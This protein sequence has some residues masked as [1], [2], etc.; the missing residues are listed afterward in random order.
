MIIAGSGVTVVPI[1][2]IRR[3][4]IVCVMMTGFVQVFHPS[5][6]VE[7]P[8]DPRCKAAG[9]PSRWRGRRQE[10]RSA[11]EGGRGSS[12]G[13]Q[14]KDVG[15]D[16]AIEEDEDE[17]QRSQGE[18]SGERSAEAGSRWLRGRGWLKK[19]AGRERCI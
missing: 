17:R 3:S 12:G 6:A 7:G 9:V 5:R 15:H 10:A 1:P 11:R 2:Y 14:V 18:T 13:E 8:P 16:A 19:V 4:D